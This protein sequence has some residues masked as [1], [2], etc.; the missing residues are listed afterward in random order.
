[1]NREQILELFNQA[2]DSAGW[3]PGFGNDKVIDYLT[4]FYH[5][6]IGLFLET[7]GQ[8]V[9][10]DASR[11]AAISEAIQQYKD[12][13]LKDVGKPVPVSCWWE[14]SEY[15]IDDPE[16]HAYECGMEVG[17][18]FEL[19]AAYYVKEEFKVVAVEEGGDLELEYKNPVKLYTESQLL[20]AVA[21]KDEEI[22]RL[23]SE[24]QY[25][26]QANVGG[27]KDVGELCSQL[28]AAQEEIAHLDRTKAEWKNTA[29]CLESQ[30]A[31]A[32]EPQWQPIETA[33]KTGAHLAIDIPNDCGRRPYVIVWLDADHPDADGAGWYE[34]W[35]FDPVGPTHWLPLPA[36]PKGE[37]K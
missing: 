32:Q 16:C 13:L 34:H 5:L 11:E 15:H 7:T 30:L 36:A 21:K 6:S 17:A 20:A 10:N 2:G 23:T 26:V 35:S 19:A 22:E 24:L 8:Y 29:K 14:D 1:M 37:V 3:K 4:H 25:S 12:S 27:L 28:K 31:A 18:E 9:T 33:P